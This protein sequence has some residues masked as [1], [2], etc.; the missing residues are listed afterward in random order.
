[1]IIKSF[2]KY[3]KVILTPRRNWERAI[4]NVSGGEQVCLNIAAVQV[5]SIVRSGEFAQQN[6]A[7]QRDVIHFP[8]SCFTFILADW[9]TWYSQER[10]EDFA[11]ITNK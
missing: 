6:I 1:M 3:C 9:R 8:V 11:D 2:V 4:K 5:H 10:G 7:L